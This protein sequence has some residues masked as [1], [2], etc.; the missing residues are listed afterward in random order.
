M[1]Q[2]QEYRM[3]PL[4]RVLLPSAPL[5]SVQWSSALM[6]S[7]PLSSVQRSSALLMSALLPSVPTVVHL[8]VLLLV[9]HRVCPP[10]HGGDMQVVQHQEH[11]MRPSSRVPLSSASLLSVQWASTLLLRALL[12][13][14]VLRLAHLADVH[15]D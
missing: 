12:R 5:P 1:V 8:L 3:R 7:A 6:M 10:Q 9:C 11:R 2:D 4:S 13:A 14:K 15:A